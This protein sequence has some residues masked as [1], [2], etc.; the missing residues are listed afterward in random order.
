MDALRVADRYFDAWN[1]RDPEGIAASLGEDGTYS[2]PN[3][4]DGLGPAATAE[5]A[6]GLFAGFP[7]LAFAIE[8]EA[9]CGDGLVCAEWRMTG[10]NLGSFMGLPPTGRAVSLPGADVIRVEGD[11][12]RS[13]HGYFDSR[14]VPEQLG[15]QVVVQPRA[16]R[17][18][19]LRRERGG[20]PERRRARR[21]E[22][23][24][25]RGAHPGGAGRGGR[26]RPADRPG[27]A[28]P[29]GFHQLARGH[30]GR[31]RCTPSPPGR[32]P[33]TRRPCARARPT[34][35][36]C[37]ASSARASPP[38]ARPGSGRPTGSTACGCAA[39]PAARWCGRRPR[40]PCACGARAA[41]AP[42]LLVRR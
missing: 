25:A 5:Y 13:V 32:A 39:R 2:D 9:A 16:D 26:A 4:P 38:G 14:V 33:T 10:T 7:D 3:V 41:G 40:G 1:R 12:V 19:R 8:Q 21:R 6:A 36:R 23:H 17:P 20:G 37:A 34:P 35:T 42:A 18:V 29:A 11:R 15:L 27:V 28:R 22:P 24:R 30:R 31:A